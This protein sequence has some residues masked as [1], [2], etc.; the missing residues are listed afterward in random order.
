[1]PICDPCVRG[2]HCGKPGEKTTHCFC[3]H[4]PRASQPPRPQTPAH[5]PVASAMDAPH[6]DGGGRPAD[7]DTRPFTAL[8]AEWMRH[9]REGRFSEA[10][11][12][13]KILI[14]RL[15]GMGPHR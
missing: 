6:P 14:S 2:D 7:D 5:G 13:R 1:M 4:R 15:Q 8:L 12:L 9:H 11:A 3:Q 10:R